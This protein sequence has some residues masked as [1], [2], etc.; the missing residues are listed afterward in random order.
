[1]ALDYGS[2][3]EVVQ[4]AGFGATW[5]TLSPVLRPLG[6]L[7]LSWLPLRP[8][9]F[10]CAALTVAVSLYGLAR[11]M[12]RSAIGWS[13]LLYFAIL[14]VWPYASGRVLWIMLPLVVLIGGRGGV[15]LWR[16]R[17]FRVP[18]TLPAG[19]GP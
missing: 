19:V 6:D 3:A 17:P 7:F 1:M 18:A 9:Y 14:A 12:R 8:L 11:V 5:S 13:L 10:L 4:Q 16:D 2:C 15:G